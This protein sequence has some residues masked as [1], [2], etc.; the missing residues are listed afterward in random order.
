MTTLKLGAD[1]GRLLLL[2]EVQ[3]RPG[4]SIMQVEIHNEPK[5]ARVDQ[6]LPGIRKRENRAQRAVRTDG[7]YRN[8]SVKK[9]IYIF[10]IS[11]SLVKTMN[12]SI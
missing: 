11:G 5:R 8:S 2:V 10:L 6:V 3:K 12:A 9:K 7:S 4:V 1:A